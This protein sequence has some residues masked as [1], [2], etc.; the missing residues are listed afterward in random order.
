MA[1]LAAP[2]P[3]SAGRI[4]QQAFVRKAAEEFSH[5]TG[6]SSRACPR[7]CQVGRDDTNSPGRGGT[8]SQPQRK[9][10]PARAALEACPT[11]AGLAGLVL[12]CPEGAGRAF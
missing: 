10:C 5:A 9:V 4:P 12:G 3:T 2:L 6:A 1:E 7:F 8:R 11:C